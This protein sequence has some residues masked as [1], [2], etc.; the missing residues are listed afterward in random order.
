MKMKDKVVMVTGG[1]R[2]IGRATVL[3]FV[4]EGAKVSWCDLNEEASQEL[5]K[6]IGEEHCFSTVN[7]GKAPSVRE[8]AKEVFDRYGRIDV[9]VNNA[10]IT[11]DNFLVK[12]KNG[13]LVKEMPEQDFSDVIDINLKGVFHCTQAVAPYMVRQKKGVILSA[14]SIVSSY[15]NLGQTNYAAAKAGVV[16]MTKVWAREFGRHNIRVNTVSPGF[17]ETDMVKAVPAKVI[18]QMCAQTPLQ[19]LGQPEEIANIYCW[20]ASDEASFITGTN[21]AADGGLVLGT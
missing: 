15:G 19:R 21:I 4:K 7:V 8:W 3:K 10:G 5:L 6:E 17:I 1:A 2:G 18:E 16:G 20:L 11:R 14:S 12:V 9:L 13:E